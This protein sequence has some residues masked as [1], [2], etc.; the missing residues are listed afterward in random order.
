[1]LVIAAPHLASQNMTSARDMGPSSDTNGAV[2]GDGVDFNAIFSH[3]PL[4]SCNTGVSTK[5]TDVS[6][7]TE[8]LLK[9]G[10]LHLHF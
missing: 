1:M 6:N 7:V 10:I 9:F 8:G 2:H 5:K 3:P 4:T